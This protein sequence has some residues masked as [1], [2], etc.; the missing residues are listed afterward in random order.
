MPI[1]LDGRI[2]LHEDYRSFENTKLQLV[3][4]TVTESLIQ[5][6]NVMKAEEA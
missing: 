4:Q 6:A 1:D 5:A 3:R 2:K